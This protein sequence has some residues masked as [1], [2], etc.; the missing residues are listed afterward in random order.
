MQNKTFLIA[1]YTYQNSS[2]LQVYSYSKEYF[3]HRN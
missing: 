2:S 3:N 1:S